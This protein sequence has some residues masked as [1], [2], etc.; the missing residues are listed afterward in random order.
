VLNAYLTVE[1]TRRTY[2]TGSGG[3]TKGKNE[4]FPITNRVKEIATKNGNTLEQN[5]GYN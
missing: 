3:F 2:K 5:P 1:K 4:Y